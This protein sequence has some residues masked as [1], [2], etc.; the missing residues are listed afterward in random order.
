MNEV[1]DD[2][3]R[4]QRK[5]DPCSAQRVVVPNACSEKTE[6]TVCPTVMRY[7]HVISPR[8]YLVHQRFRGS[9]YTSQQA[10][11]TFVGQSMQIR[12]SSFWTISRS[13]CLIFS[14]F[15]FAEAIFVS[16]SEL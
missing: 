8:I 7:H 2:K 6:F 13:T 9:A 5:A 11:A 15:R 14:S 16:W 12:L 1:V 4:A 10:G 3:K